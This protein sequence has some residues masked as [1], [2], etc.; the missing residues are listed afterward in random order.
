MRK[1][2]F[3]RVPEGLTNA[4]FALLGV[5]ITGL[6]NYI[7]VTQ[8][9]AVSGKQACVARIDQREAVL[10]QKA[11]SFMVA[12]AGTVAPST[13][14]L[15]NY[16]VVEKASDELLRS[17]YALSSYTDEHLGGLTELLALQISKR[18]DLSKQKD[19]SPESVAA[20]AKDSQE[21]LDNWRTSFRDFMLSLEMYR[22][23][24]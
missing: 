9:A 13:H 24:C 15:V 17:A 16:E 1:R 23:Q 7:S 10:R 5:L 8:T 4:A 3:S 6:V 2:T 22:E 21:T 14:A 11:E 12:L 19:R 20:L 18:L